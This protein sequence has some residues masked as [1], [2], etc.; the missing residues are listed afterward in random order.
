V[1]LFFLHFG[2]LR[3]WQAYTGTSQ[4]NRKK[5]LEDYGG[6]KMIDILWSIVAV[7]CWGL[8]IVL[9]FAGL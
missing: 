5:N 7:V 9:L 1:S 2:N 4:R 3:G 8:M 6:G